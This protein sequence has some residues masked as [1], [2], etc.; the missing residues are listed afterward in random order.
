MCTIVINNK[1]YDHGILKGM[2]IWQGSR[3]QISE[4]PS[5]LRY[6]HII[7]LSYL[8]VRVQFCL[9]WWNFL[10]GGS[11]KNS[12]NSWNDIVL[13][14][15]FLPTIQSLP[16]KTS[17]VYVNKSKLFVACYIY[18]V[19]SIT[20]NRLNRLARWMVG[21]IQNYDRGS[22]IVRG[23]YEGGPSA[24]IHSAPTVGLLQLQTTIL[25]QNL[26]FT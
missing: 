1:K 24:I 19:F 7:Y 9:L 26:T 17:L 16:S 14:F 12:T 3:A 20:N 5:M 11:G 18:C 6:T 2:T 22:V 8:L 13:G 21:D 15:A 4:S 10:H 25:I 23:W